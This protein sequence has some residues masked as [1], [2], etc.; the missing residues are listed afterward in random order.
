VI[1]RTLAALALAAVAVVLSACGAGSVADPVAAAATKTQQAGGVKVT[2]RIA[3][4]IGGVS[5]GTVTADGVFDQNQGEMDLDMSSLLQLTGLPTGSGA[6]IKELYLQENGDPV[7]YLDIPFLASQLPGGKSWVRLDLQQ[8][9][10]VLGLDVNKLLGQSG[11]NP[12]QT[13]AMLQ[14]SGQVQK[15]GPDIVGGVAVTRYHA[16]VDLKKAL[17]LK[18]VSEATARRLIDAGAP[19][20]LPVDVWI[21]N[22]DGLVHQFRMTQTAQANG[23]SVSTLLTMTLNDW[24]TPVTVHAPPADQVYDVSKL[25]SSGQKA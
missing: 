25:V 5:S 3:Y 13:L 9:G 11:E 14:A 17:E 8:A 16:V 1:G 15:V 4:S 23:R 10:S 2:M 24:G 18:G 20:E 12:T 7:L 19:T 21:G 22:D 6:G